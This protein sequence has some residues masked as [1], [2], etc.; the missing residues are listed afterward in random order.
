MAETSEMELD[1]LRRRA[2]RC[3]HFVQRHRAAD[4]MIGGDLYL[5]QRRSTTNPRP[6]SLLKYATAD[7]VHA[8]L[9]EVE[10]KM[11]RSQ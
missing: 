2:A 3:G 6:P 9:A 8:A 1:L 10:R 11:F 5:Q 4:T 7:Q